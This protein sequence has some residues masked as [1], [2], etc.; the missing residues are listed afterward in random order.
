MNFTGRNLTCVRG[1]RIVFQGLDFDVAEGTSL[2]LRGSN[3]SGKSSLLRMA[4]GFLAPEDGSFGWGSNALDRE[5]HSQH[6]AYVGHLDA[7]KSTFSVLEN[8]QFW[9]RIGG[10][11][12]ST[13]L[14]ALEAMGISHLAGLPAGFLSAGQRRRLNLAR[15]AASTAP[16]WLLDEPTVSLDEAAIAQL[17]Q[18]LRRHL[19]GGGLAM[20]ATHTDL[21]LKPATLLMLGARE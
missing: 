21:P 13:S 5:A 1:G 16:L 6:I 14:N 20:I 19:S 4:A 2:L 8:L 3:G 12:E 10:G 11:E 15:L 7:V 18:L 17:M 9:T